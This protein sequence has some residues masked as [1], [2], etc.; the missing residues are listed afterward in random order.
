VGDGTMYKV[1]INIIK[2]KLISTGKISEEELNTKIK[3]KVE[4]LSG[5]ISE[6]GAAHIIANELGI[7][8]EEEK[9][10]QEEIK[11]KD[12]LPNMKNVSLVGKVVRKFNI[13]EF[14][15][16]DHKGKVGSIVFGDETGTMRLVFWNDLTEKMESFN[17]D[18]ILKVENVYIKENNNQKEA[19]LNSES[20]LIVNPENVK[21]EGVKTTNGYSRKKIEHLNENLGNVEVVG[22]VVQVF[23]PRFFYTCS[24]C[25]KKVMDN[26]GS[27]SCAEHGKVEPKISYVTNLVL[28]D[29]TGNIRG[30]FWKN[31][32]NHLFSLKDEEVAEFKEDLSKF[33]SLKT[34]LLGEQ[35]KLKGTIKKNDM[36]NRLEFNVQIVEK[37]N[38]EEE[39]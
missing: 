30:I 27:Y 7:K 15:K 37:A 17:E 33:D 34:D 19:H 13:N 21:I 36:F 5:L 12:V 11:I 9:I 23:D 31:Q 26:E 14:S 20:E 10:L 8:I 39:L 25:G 24:Q 16:G 22:T 32:T 6:E 28:D 1:P 3:S 18:D 4:E 38:P 35:L 29:G 2:E